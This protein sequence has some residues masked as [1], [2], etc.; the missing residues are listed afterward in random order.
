MQINKQK[1][2]NV[3]IIILYYLN[4]INKKLENGLEIS[5]FDET[6]DIKADAMIIYIYED[7][8]CA[9]D[10]LFLNYI[11]GTEFRVNNNKAY[12]DT[13][14]WKKIKKILVND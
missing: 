4:P 13:I 8:H 9:N 1:Y 11:D 10:T 3:P 6:N 7:E 14:A 5:Y 12:G 2:I